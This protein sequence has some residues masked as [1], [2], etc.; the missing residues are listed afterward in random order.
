MVRLIPLAA[1][2]LSVLTLSAEAGFTISLDITGSGNVKGELNSLTVLDSSTDTSVFV[3]QTGGSVQFTATPV[4]TVLLD[5]GPNQTIAV[6]SNLAVN[7]NWTK[8]SSF[9][10]WSGIP[11]VIPGGGPNTLNPTTLNAFDGQTYNIGATFTAGTLSSVAFDFDNNG[12]F[13][14]AGNLNNT[15]SWSTLQSLGV[16]TPGSTYTVGV[17]LIESGGSDTDT[18]DFTI[19]PLSSVPEPSSMALL[20][21]I[22]VVSVGFRQFRI[23]F[24]RKTVPKT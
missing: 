23:R 10:F 21:S 1:V 16:A 2:L 8:S 20:G 14:T 24:R 5:A 3:N 11:A 13:E 4:T 7:L 22:A 6:N 19:Q 12:S 17:R 15:F 18:F 9:A